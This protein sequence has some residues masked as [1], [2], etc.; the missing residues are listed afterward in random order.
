MWKR[1]NPP[2][3]IAAKRFEFTVAVAVP[4]R[5]SKLDGGVTGWTRRRKIDD[6]LMM[7]PKR[8]Y[9][10]STT[11]ARE[12]KVVHSLFL[13]SIFQHLR[14]DLARSSRAY[15]RGTTEL[16]FSRITLGQRNRFDIND[17]HRRANSVSNPE[18]DSCTR[19]LK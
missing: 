8:V 9:G 2:S 14:S 3:R 5:E 11:H 7:V 15:H 10:I 17:A 19:N 18:T 1:I 16:R 4:A 12:S 13:W 6:R